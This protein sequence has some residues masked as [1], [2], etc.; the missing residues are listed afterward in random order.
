[1]A[2][3]S[4]ILFRAPAAMLAAAGIFLAV[5]CARPPGDR[6]GGNAQAVQPAGP[7]L[8][9]WNVEVREI[10][11]SGPQYRLLSDRASYAVFARTVRAD[12]VTLFL[13]GSPS[14]MVVRSPELT[15]EMNEGRVLLARGGEA[16]NGE[17]WTAEVP[18]ASFLLKE[19]LMTATGIAKLSGPGV[20]VTGD[21]L[22][23]DWPR[24]RLSM[25]NART[26]VVSPR[27]FRGTR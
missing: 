1:M 13:P 21:N 18:E 17:G 10:R 8:L 16:G 3:R 4:R 15:W 23:W 2:L 7:E 9:L 12:N 27:D 24:A 6:G 22:V 19:G 20:R 5:A 11:P 26:R 14:G 25:S